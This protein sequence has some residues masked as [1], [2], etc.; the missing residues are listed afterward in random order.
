LE[1]HGKEI[2]GDGIMNPEISSPKTRDEIAREEATCNPIFLL[3][4]YSYSCGEECKHAFD[5]M[6][7]GSGEVDPYEPPCDSQS[8][9]CPFGDAYEREGTRRELTV[10]VFSTREEGEAFGRSQIHNLG[11]ENDGWSAYCVPAT[12]ALADLLRFRDSTQPQ[13]PAEGHSK[14][15]PG[16]GLMTEQSTKEPPYPGCQDHKYCC[17]SCD[18]FTKIGSCMFLTRMGESVFTTPT[19][20]EAYENGE[21]MFLNAEDRNLIGCLGCLSH[22]SIRASGLTGFTSTEILA[23]AK[24]DW[25]NREERKGNHPEAPWIAGW[26]NGF[27]TMHKPDWNKVKEALTRKDEQIKQEKWIVDV[28]GDL[29]TRKCNLFDNGFPMMMPIEEVLD[30]LR[31]GVHHGQ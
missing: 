18:D 5:Q 17:K 14:E 30:L 26:M 8:R 27:M 4:Q 24:N 3:K 7:D 13:D 28:I 15:T 9:E 22:S 10:T 11:K 29:N 6:P 20:K 19:P 31:K 1:G 23:L 25:H 21:G 2:A 12:G 16:S